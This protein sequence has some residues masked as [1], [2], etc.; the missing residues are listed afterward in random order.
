[1]DCF[2]LPHNFDDCN[3]WKGQTEKFMPSSKGKKEYLKA[4]LIYNASWICILEAWEEVIIKG[5]SVMIAEFL[6][7]KSAL[8]PKWS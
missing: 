4:A 7:R 5:R 2:L 6:T 3:L 8:G 1:M